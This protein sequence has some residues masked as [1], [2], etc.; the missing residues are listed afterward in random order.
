MLF[1]GQSQHTIDAKL[2]LAIPAKIRSQWKPSRDG[3]AW[4]CIPWPTGHLRLYTEAKFKELAERGEDSL[5]PR[6][7]EASVEA[8]LY[9]Y[10]ERLEE[11]KAGRI[12]IPKQHME[13]AGIGMDVVLVGA[14]SRLEV[15]SQTAWNASAKDNF[16]RLAEMIEAIRDR[17]PTPGSGHS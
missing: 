16:N 7:D 11:D 3:E 17:A 12:M 9:G 10:A 5:T 8:V 6:K 14:K 4:Y 1:T 13:L 2:R 15:H